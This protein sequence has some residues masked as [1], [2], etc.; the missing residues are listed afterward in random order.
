MRIS[1][2]KQEDKEI[3]DQKTSNDNDT[4]QKHRN[5]GTTSTSWI[6]P[7]R[8]QTAA[9]LQARQTAFP[10]NHSKRWNKEELIS[11]P[12]PA[13]G[14]AAM[15]EDEHVYSMPSYA[16]NFSFEPNHDFTKGVS[17]SSSILTQQ[18][19]YLQSSCDN[20]IE[21][22]SFDT[23]TE[24]K[25]SSG[26]SQLILN[27]K[28]VDQ[29][30]RSK[31]KDAKMKTRPN[32]HELAETTVEDITSKEQTLS[33]EEAQKRLIDQLKQ[34][35]NVLSDENKELTV[36]STDLEQALVK[37]KQEHLMDNMTNK[38]E[39]EERNLKLAVLEQ[40]FCAL[41]SGLYESEENTRM[42]AVTDSEI[43]TTM[44]S[45]ETDSI[46]NEK[47]DAN[48][49]T[50]DEN[51]NVNG[52]KSDNNVNV[53][54]KARLPPTV[55]DMRNSIVRIDKGYYMEL[56]GKVKWEEA[57]RIKAQKVNEILAERIAKLEKAMEHKEVEARET[58]EKQERTIRSLEHDLQ[59]CR[60]AR[61]QNPQKKKS[62]HR[63]RTT[64]SGLPSMDNM[65]GSRGEPDEDDGSTSQ[66]TSHATDSMAESHRVPTEEEF[67]EILDEKITEA[68]SLAL[69]EKEREHALTIDILS[70]QLETKDKIISQME[71]KVYNLSK[72]TKEK[73]SPARKGIPYDVLLRNIGVTNELMDSSIQRLENMMAQLDRD[74]KESD[75]LDEFVPIRRL[76]TKISLVQH[77]MR[78]ALKLI[79]QRLMNG[80]ESIRYKSSLKHR[81]NLDD[82]DSDSNSQKSHEIEA[83]IEELIAQIQETATKSFKETEAEVKK[84]IDALKDS[85]HSF[86]FQLTSKQDMVE[87]LELACAEHVENFRNLQEKFEELKTIKEGKNEESLK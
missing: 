42:D 19:D 29:V 82:G 13:T 59:Q 26:F 41:N 54:A 79:E 23:P 4:T 85:L 27:A 61:F 66:A 70:R 76:G 3:E 47:K 31:V 46:D 21:P 10:S 80:V 40:H 24:I 81:A 32:I 18:Q 1:R 15:R 35:L 86:E 87:A 20:F 52:E 83:S 56:E 57:E 33:V 49:V 12:P 6:T 9:I 22:P 69:D 44:S 84:E 38:K 7:L 36:K 11:A 55:D 17:S 50:V 8:R 43:P 39:V 58:F 48:V 63:R 45:M 37:E 53:N 71:T 34:A 75:R 14:I 5:G 68:V 74:E 51:I 25:M 16:D 62:G 64:V 30:H 67:K 72:S 65:S 77:E 60:L 2:V 73:S 28:K 78:V